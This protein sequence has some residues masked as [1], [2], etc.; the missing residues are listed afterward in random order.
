MQRAV[1]HHK[2][3]VTG[4]F[5]L[6]LAQ[7]AAEARNPAARRKRLLDGGHEVPLRVQHVDDEIVLE[8]GGAAAVVHA[9]AAAQAGLDGVLVG[10]S[11]RRLLH[12]PGV[13]GAAV[14]CFAAPG[15]W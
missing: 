14:D 9:A 4:R 15:T 13:R 3:R 8:A 11:P 5:L 10:H 2:S 6:E 1:F 12:H 7:A